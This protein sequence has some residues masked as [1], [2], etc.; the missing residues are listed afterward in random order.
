[1][2]DIVSLYAN[3]LH[4]LGLRALLDYITKYRNLIPIR[5]SEEFILEAAEFVLKNNNFILLEEM[6]NQVMGTAMGTKF[7]PPYANLSV[8]FLEETV[9]FPVKLPKYFP[10]DNCKL[11]EDLFKRYMDDGY[12]P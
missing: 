6:L 3:I 12:L 8:G 4:E 2:C 1:M 7:A 11:I 5:L 10:H 9:L